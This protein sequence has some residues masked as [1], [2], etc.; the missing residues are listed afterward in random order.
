MPYSY[1]GIGG[2]YSGYNNGG[3]YGG[4]SSLS[5]LSNKTNTNYNYTSTVTNTNNTCAGQ[6][7]CNVVTN[8]VAQN[9][10]TLEGSCTASGSYGT[11]QTVTWT[12]NATGGN[13]GYTYSWSGDAYGNGSS[14]SN[15]Y[16]NG[17]TKSATV[18]ITSNGQSITRNCSTQVNNN[19][20]Q[21]L[22][23]YCS[24]S[25]SGNNVATF[26][27][28]A[29]GGNGSNYNYQWSGD[30]YGNGS[31]VTQSFST[32]GT[33]SATVRITDGGGQSVTQTCNVYVGGN[34]GNITLV[35]NGGNT[36]N[37]GT[38]ASGVYL[39]DI[40][41]TGVGE[42]LKMILFVLGM[43]LW[44]AFMAWVFL[45]KKAAK[46]GMTQREMIAKFKRDNLARK[47]IIA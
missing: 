18:T 9:T 19:Y 8:Q 40:P 11:N 3:G 25:V 4:N 23:G 15:T 46:L 14:V 17:G 44:S 16:Y 10:N 1:G 7:N 12:A 27:A 28:N 41:Y 26:T 37:N 30:V 38:L 5:F 39:S 36:P 35:S 42:N 34:N 22:S 13:G 47:G 29:N 32:S 33:K 24:A 21:S 31:V 45:K 6:G 43:T 2:G 20:N